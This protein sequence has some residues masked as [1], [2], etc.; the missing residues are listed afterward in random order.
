MSSRRKLKKN[1]NEIMEI[2]YTDS[3]MYKVFVVNADVKAADKII[4]EI[5]EK[6]LDLLKRVSADE[7][8]QAK[9][10][11]KAYYKKLRADV[12]SQTNAIAKEIAALS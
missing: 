9:G 3:V 10:R 12:V 11:V 7:G 5:A 1:I 8:K 2:L 4:E 6:H